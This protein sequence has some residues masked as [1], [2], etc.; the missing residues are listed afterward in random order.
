MFV[1]ELEARVSLGD[2]LLTGALRV[3]LVNDLTG[4]PGRTVPE[5]EVTVQFPSGLFA[6]AELSGGLPRRYGL[7]SL[8]E[9]SP[10]AIDDLSLGLRVGYTFD[11]DALW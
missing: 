8:I 7:G 5:A 1:P 9:A 4:G 3:G 10:L 2:A 11:L 6:G